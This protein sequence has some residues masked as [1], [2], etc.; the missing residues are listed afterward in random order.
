MTPGTFRLLA[1]GLHFVPG[2]VWAVLAREEW[3]GLRR[4]PGSTLFRLLVLVP[5]L[6]AC[7]YL[8]YALIVLL[9]M[10]LEGPTNPLRAG[11]LVLLDGGVAAVLACA[12]HLVRVWP[13][14]SEPPDR[15]WLVRN[16]GGCT[17]AGLLFVLTD[18]RA[19]P[20]GHFFTTLTG[21]L[22]VM[23]AL[24][25]RGVR[26][27]SHLGS[28]W[29]VGEIRSLDAVAVGSGFLCLVAAQLVPPLAGTTTI[30]LMLG[31]TPSPAALWMFSL[32]AVGSL[33][34]AVPFALRDTADVGRGF[35]VGAIL[36]GV[37]AGIYLGVP[38][39]AARVI[40]PEL[41]RLLD[42]AAILGLVVVLLLG[43]PWVH[44]GVDR[45]VFRRHRQRWEGLQAFLQTLTPE[46]GTVECCR[47]T[48]ANVARAFQLRRAA[49]LLRDGEQI[50]HGDFPLEPLAR[51]WPRGPA[52]GA[53]PTFTFGIGGMRELPLPLKEAL[54][55]ADVVVVVPITS[56]RGRWGDLFICIGTLGAT[57]GWDEVQAG[58]AFAAQLGLVLDG[59][60]LLARAVAVERSLAHAEKLAAIGELAARI[61]HEIRNP[62][63][64]A[65]SL[66]QQ[67]A[68]APASPDDAEPAGLILV[69]LERVERQVAAL[70]RFARREEFRFEPVDLGELARVTV[71]TFRPRLDAAGVEVDLE[72]AEG[73][74]ARADRE[75][76][77][78]VLINLIENA[79]D[80]LAE[81]PG[82][83]RLSLAVGGVNG[84]ATLRL[85]DTGPGLPS[86]AL[87]HL[88]EPFFSR[89][90]HGTGLGLAIA[91]R[92]VDA[93]GGRI[94]ARS[95]AGGGAA[96]E[97]EL[98]LAG[99]P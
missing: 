37:T 60:E 40:D 34:L 48:L 72:L 25:M 14:R 12:R 2:L 58:E 59:A 69:E 10:R 45:L 63:T 86:D 81:T 67:L 33:A 96:F 43:R 11:L 90:P 27:R 83:R 3:R 50:A 44:A 99:G 71:D 93:H 22:V 16:Y 56:P 57:I 76:L 64:A 17:L 42:V 30:A 24:T 70:L 23:A 4:R 68:R 13:I 35:L 77:R 21:F 73:V 54:V 74:V 62:V 89:K 88:F 9:P 26:Q 85:V 20:A 87:P 91:R 18:L 82:R 47:R 92:T 55:E 7:L 8:L 79:L 94:A 31:T 49:I 61:A 52:A 15:G 39:L 29:G 84:T 41:R 78:Q 98:P 5:G 38:A 1:F 32:N 46:L 97:V 80:A 66:A 51:V 36:I 53:L 6:V 65:R 19:V 95:A 75:K 28:W